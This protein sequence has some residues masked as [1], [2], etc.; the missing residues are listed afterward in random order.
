MF[1]QMIRI[2][3][4]HVNYND[5]RSCKSTTPIF[6]SRQNIG[7]IFSH[8]TATKNPLCNI[9]KNGTLRNMVPVIIAIEHKLSVF[10]FAKE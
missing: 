4:P 2:L 5:P 6:L 3:R 1:D 7:H 9:I 8:D 10:H